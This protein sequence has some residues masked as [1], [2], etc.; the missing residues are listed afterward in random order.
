MEILTQYGDHCVLLNMVG[1][2]DNNT[3]I[4]GNNKIDTVQDLLKKCKKIRNFGT[5]YYDVL[6]GI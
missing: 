1:F 3:T 4:T 6:E 5:T 2:I